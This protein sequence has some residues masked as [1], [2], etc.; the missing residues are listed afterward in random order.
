MDIQVVDALEG[1]IANCDRCAEPLE[2]ARPPGGDFK[3]NLQSETKGVDVV[4]NTVRL[5][6]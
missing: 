6:L 2:A 4:K 3:T 5:A 1:H